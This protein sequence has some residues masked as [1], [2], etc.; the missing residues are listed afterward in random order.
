MDDYLAL[1]YLMAL[2]QNHVRD[3]KNHIYSL[4]KIWKISVTAQKKKR[5]FPIIP[6]PTD[7]RACKYNKYI[8][9]M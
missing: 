4:Y 1:P 5:E 9:L 8:L 3:Y 6:P 7:I 2:E